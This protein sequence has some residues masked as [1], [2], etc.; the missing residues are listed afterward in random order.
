MAKTE[1]RELAYMYYVERGFTQKDTA[2]KT[3]VTSKTV[4]EWIKK[5]GWKEIRTAKT[6]SPD[7]LIKNY[8]ELLNILVEKRLQIMASDDKDYKGITDEISKVSKAIEN[9]RKDSTPTLRTHIYCADLYFNKLLDD[10]DT[11]KT[12][13]QL[14]DFTRNYISD[15]ATKQ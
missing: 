7:K 4:R 12:R 11:V 6:T 1:A 2:E 13:S 14:V 5:F 9:L 3:G 15:L 10:F 8:Y